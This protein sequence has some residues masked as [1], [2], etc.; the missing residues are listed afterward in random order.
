MTT[1]VWGACGSGEQASQLHNMREGATH[2]GIPALQQRFGAFQQEAQVVVHHIRWLLW[3]SVIIFIFFIK[4]SF[5]IIN[6]IVLKSIPSNNTIRDKS[7]NKNH[8]SENYTKTYKIERFV[9]EAFEKKSKNCFKLFPWQKRNDQLFVNKKFLL[10]T[11]TTFCQSKRK[12]V[13][14]LRTA[15][16][17]QWHSMVNQPP[18]NSRRN[19]VLLGLC[20]F[21]APH[22]SYVDLATYLERLLIRDYWHEII[23]MRLLIWDR[24][25]S[26][27]WKSSQFNGKSKTSNQGRQSGKFSQPLKFWNIY[28]IMQIFVVY[29]IF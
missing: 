12:Y 2:G 10:N 29:A 11:R 1:C 4:W 13:I 5:C 27:R 26:I 9:G 15:N 7:T 19:F 17:L 6:S 16:T 20:Y 22:K 28:N 14:L 8:L 21:D 25:R 3:S 23:D 24:K 18:H